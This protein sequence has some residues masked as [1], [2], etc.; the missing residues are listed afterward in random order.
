MFETYCEHDW[1]ADLQIGTISVKKYSRYPRQHGLLHQKLGAFYRDP[2]K[3][4]SN[5]KRYTY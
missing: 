1:F 4:S 2:K 3:H 5:R